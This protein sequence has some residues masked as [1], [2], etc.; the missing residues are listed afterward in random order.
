MTVRKGEA[1]GGPGALPADG[2]VVDSD[3]AA[4]RV[5]TEARRSNR[6]IPALGLLGGDLA[7]TCGATGREDRLRGPDAQTLPVDLGEV[8][9]DGALHFFVAHLVARR[10]WWR[11][12]VVAAMNAQFLGDWD[13]APRSHPGDGRLDLVQADL[14]IGDRWKART[15]L[16]SGTHVP[17]PGI[18]ERRVKAVQLD[19]APGTAVWLDGERVGEAK[20]LSVRVVPDALTV[21]V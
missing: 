18:S 14:A 1:W 11:G 4:R 12:P 21:V 17:H 8:L 15:R 13:V 6:P 20:A 7:R 9:V 10:S 5:V 19:L 3:L 2:V 16:R